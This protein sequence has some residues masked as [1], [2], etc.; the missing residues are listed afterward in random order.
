MIL[1]N[2]EA[3]KTPST[4]MAFWMVI[5]GLGDSVSIEHMLSLTRIQWLRRIQSPSLRGVL[6][7]TKKFSPQVDTNQPH[8]KVLLTIKGCHSQSAML[9]CYDGF[10]GL[11]LRG[12]TQ[13][14]RLEQGVNGDPCS[15]PLSSILHIPTDPSLFSTLNDCSLPRHG[16]VLINADSKLDTPASCD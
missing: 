3:V 11:C 15:C 10:K 4:N 16:R 13:G 1:H 7:L 6:W 5:H 8:E 14:C 12:A 2:R 9:H